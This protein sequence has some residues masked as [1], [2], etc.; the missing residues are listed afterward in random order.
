[1][2]IRSNFRE[3]AVTRETLKNFANRQ[4]MQHIS[5]LTQRPLYGLSINK[6]PEAIVALVV[7]HVVTIVVDHQLWLSRTTDLITENEKK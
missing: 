5:T 2:R 4:N 3:Y 6:M 1:M 7:V